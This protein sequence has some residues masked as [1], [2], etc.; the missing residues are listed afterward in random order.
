[1]LGSLR[2]LPRIVTVLCASCVLALGCGDSEGAGGS[3]DASGL[4]DACEAYCQAS[5]SQPCGEMVLTV[6]QCQQQCQSAPLQTQGFCEEE[7]AAAFECSA[8]GGFT[9]TSYDSDGDGVEDTS[10]P[11][12]NAPC[13]EQQ[14]AYATCESTAGCDRM[15]AEADAQGCGDGCLARCEGRMAELDQAGLGCGLYYNGYANCSA[16]VGLS[17]EGGAPAPD[18]L[19]LDALF[20]AGECANP[21]LAS[22]DLCPIYCFAAEEIGCSSDCSADCASREA[23][24]TCGAAWVDLLDCVTFF[25]DATCDAG[26]LLPTADGI[27]SS[28]RDAYQA[29][30]G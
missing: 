20:Q 30:A 6:E 14:Q 25:G 29:C 12:P 15:C 10:V 17:C 23:D 5:L 1:M 7:A 13:A 4:V 8:E 26:V 24:P 19:C 16:L 21:D 2:M 9:C 28:E 27:C 11:T 18:E 22:D 3:A